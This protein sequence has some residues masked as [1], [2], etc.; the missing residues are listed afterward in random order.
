MAETHLQSWSPDSKTLGAQ[1]QGGQHP[2]AC[3]GVGQ[4]RQGFVA[5]RK[6]SQIKSVVFVT[7]EKPEPTF[8]HIV[9]SS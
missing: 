8:T 4:L 5:V 6:N 7:N 2:A 3:G 9:A 1:Y